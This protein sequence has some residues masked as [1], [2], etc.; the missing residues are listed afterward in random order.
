MRWP[1]VWWRRS[2]ERLMPFDDRPAVGLL[3]NI[4]TAEAE[5]V[6]AGLEEEGI[7]FVLVRADE[8]S[9]LASAAHDAAVRS[10]LGVGLA[11]QGLHACLHLKTLP[12][13][14]PFLRC[15]VADV[16]EARLL[17]GDAARVVKGLPLRF[18]RLRDPNE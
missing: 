17:G 6:T 16:E 8:V 5:A 1:L 15:T 4:A 9:D 10:R 7:P 2:G 3:L 11:M 13:E 12:L 14:H 18:P